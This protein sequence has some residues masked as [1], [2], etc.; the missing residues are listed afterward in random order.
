[1]CTPVLHASPHLHADD[2]PAPFTHGAKARIA[3]VLL[4][5]SKTHVPQKMHLLREATA[6]GQ[7][8]VLVSDTLGPSE[9][10]RKFK[11]AADASLGRL[12]MGSE[13]FQDAFNPPF[14]SRGCR[15]VYTLQAKFLGC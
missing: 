6:A 12:L 8:T 5:G 13:R 15:I 4:A 3:C 10:Q 2:A 11:R 14:K 9:K 7:S 1:M